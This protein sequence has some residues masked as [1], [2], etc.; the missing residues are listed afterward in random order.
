MKMYTVFAILRFIN[1][2]KC[3]PFAKMVEY[4]IDKS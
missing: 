1:C 4:V 2:Q 3:H